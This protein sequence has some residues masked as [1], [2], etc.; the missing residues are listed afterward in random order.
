MRPD[1]NKLIPLQ[2]KTPAILQAMAEDQ[3]LA[4]P[5]DEDGTVLIRSLPS[6]HGDHFHVGRALVSPR[7]ATGLATPNVMNAG[8][9]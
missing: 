3:G 4:N 7:H 6:A 9:R 2:L 5:P 1:P 8:Q